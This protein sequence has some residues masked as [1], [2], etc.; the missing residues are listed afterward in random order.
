MSEP[1][2]DGDDGVGVRHARTVSLLAVAE[3]AGKL[4]S[5]VMFAVAARVL[6]VADFGVF[7][8]SFNLALMVST[9]VLWGFDIALIQL[10]TRIPA[11]L[12]ELL[13]NTLA[14]RGLLIPPAVLVA[15][16]VPGAP[17]GARPVTLLLSIAVLLDSA[18]Q[19]IRS[20]A[21]V[22]DRQRSVAINLV[23][24]RLA[25]AG[26]AVAVL[27]SGGGVVGMSAAYL[28]GTL[29]GVVLMFVTGHRIGLRPRLGQVSRAGIAEIAR[30]STALGLST[31]INMLIFRIDT[32]LLGWMLNATA[33]GSYSA[34]YKLFETALFVLWSVDRV[35]LPTMAAA[36]GDEPVRRGVHR[37][38][39]VVFA[40]YFP[41]A[42]LLGIRSEEVLRL[43]FGSPYGVDSGNSLRWLMV[44]LIP[45]SVQY[46]VAAGLLARSKNR[47][48]TSA[49]IVALGINVGANL[50]LIPRFG[51]AGAAAASA[52]AMSVQALLLWG[53]LWRLVGS[54]GVLRAA[55][56]PGV[57]SVVMVPVLLTSLPLIPAAVVAAVVYGVVWL[58]V[59]GKFDPVARRTLVGMVA[60]RG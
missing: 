12:D 42:L 50:A 22:R 5:F 9:F 55:F 21:A 4:A 57:A 39:S 7:S 28:A 44:A 1:R 27:F 40:V 16:L 11:R 24:Q 52:A 29:V 32:V 51:P 58:V 38:C 37:A 49:G 10:A 15:V 45:Y 43:I 56:V 17:E 26:L 19:A 48:V 34:A 8:W 31:T 53:M 54:P 3:V 59:A 35:A 33:V 2:S 46:L 60:R 47:R 25:T 18:N 20:A 41:Y 14:L 30:G 23:V 36:E 6:G 13:S